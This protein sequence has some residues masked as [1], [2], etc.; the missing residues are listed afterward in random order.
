[1]K[2]FTP[3]ILL[4][5]FS[6]YVPCFPQQ[7]V[8]ENK[9]WSNEKNG[10]EYTGESWHS[11][12]IRFEGDTLIGET[13]YKKVLR[14]DDSLMSAWYVTGFIRETDT[15]SVY[16]RPVRS[17]KERLLYDF[18]VVEGDSIYIAD[19]GY[20]YLYVDSI[21]YLPFG[22]YNEIRRYIFLTA[23][24]YYSFAWI[25]G[26]GGRNGVLFTPQ[27]FCTV[28]EENFL[29]CFF[30]NDSL[31]FFNSYF[32][33]CFPSGSIL[34]TGHNN[35]SPPLKIIYDRDAVFINF[36][37]PAPSL[38]NLTL[39]D[40]TGRV[41]LTEKSGSNSIRL[42]MKKYNPGIYIYF[43]TTHDGVFSGKICLN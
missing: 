9:L 4:L 3:A 15:A 43:V 2:L 37:S 29:V 8:T 13:L 18:G 6:L 31:K 36:D 5:A 42:E 14:S 20:E 35:I 30:E 23:C 41:I 7:F 21:R 38:I 32:S 27:E 17:G 24:T 25:E 39:F 40:Q 19:T 16:Y 1:M 34:K 22:I 26:V 33:S 11:N 12:F 10:T 28:G